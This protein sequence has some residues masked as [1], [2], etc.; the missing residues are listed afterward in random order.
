MYAIFI[1][2]IKCIIMQQYVDQFGYIKNYNP[3]TADVHLLIQELVEN[4]PK[5]HSIMEYN[6]QDWTDIY[7]INNNTQ[8]RDGFY[9]KIFMNNLMSLSTYMDNKLN[10]YYYAWYSTGH[11]ER[12]CIYVNNSIHSYY[13]HWTKDNKAIELTRYDNGLFDGMHIKYYPKT[14]SIDEC[15]RFKETS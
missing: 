2:T 13:I 5:T 1:V 3:E 9:L 4:L 8:N 15:S 11:K 12:E 10:G 6:N 14:D 7:V